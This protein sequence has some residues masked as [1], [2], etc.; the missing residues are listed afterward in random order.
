M[1]SGGSVRRTGFI[2]SAKVTSEIQ[3]NVRK[4]IA[5]FLKLSNIN[6]SNIH[7]TPFGD[8]QDPDY[9]RN[10]RIKANITI[11]NSMLAANR[12]NY[13]CSSFRQLIKACLES[14][15]FYS[16]TTYIGQ[17][18]K[19][20]DEKSDRS[21]STETAQPE[22]PVQESTT[23]DS[24]VTQNTPTQGGGDGKKDESSANTTNNS[25]TPDQT[26]TNNGSVVTT[27]R[28]ISGGVGEL[29]VHTNKR[30]T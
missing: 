11:E 29:T 21:V 17:P 16:Q 25:P 3:D 6:D 1:V 13:T 26:I 28:T 10:T 18:V 23:E 22:T 30:D 15:F 12:I 9:E 19:L 2:L 8:Y 4:Q 24:G 5:D 20:L 7:T 27:S 14:R